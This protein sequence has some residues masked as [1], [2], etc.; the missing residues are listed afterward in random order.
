MFLL[1]NFSCTAYSMQLSH[2]LSFIFPKQLA[3]V[4]LNSEDRVEVMDSKVTI[5]ENNQISFGYVQGELEKIGNQQAEARTNHIRP[6][7]ILECGEQNHIVSCHLKIDSQGLQ[8][9][10]QLLELTISEPFLGRLPCH[11]I[12]SSY[13]HLKIASS[14]LLPPDHFLELIA[15]NHPSSTEPPLAH[16]LGI[17]FSNPNSNVFFELIISFIGDIQGLL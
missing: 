10:A 12:S 14:S 3:D 8:P 7:H 17:S 2:L 1:F 5:T 9:R 4:Q 15:L 11:L 13:R 6:E 16:D